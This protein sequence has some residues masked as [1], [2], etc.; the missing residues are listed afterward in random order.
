MIP[1]DDLV[2]KL[3]WKGI[4]ANDPI[5]FLG[6][7]CN[8][9]ILSC[10]KFLA[11]TPEQTDLHVDITLKSAGH[12]FLIVLYC[13]RG[14]QPHG[15]SPWLVARL[16]AVPCDGA[17]S[18]WQQRA[19]TAAFIV[20]FAEVW[21]RSCCEILVCDLLR[22]ATT[23]SPFCSFF[24]LRWPFCEACIPRRTEEGRGYKTG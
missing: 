21:F 20:D 18:P 4:R 11:T 5:F 14:F 7:K 9:G 24:S 23:L 13:S 8:Q 1:G 10:S 22:C 12:D 15:M 6:V 16:L 3:Q 19:L 2:V 17:A